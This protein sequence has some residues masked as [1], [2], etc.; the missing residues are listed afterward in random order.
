MFE[1]GE[2]GLMKEVGLAPVFY[3]R[4]AVGGHMPC[5]MYLTCGEDAAEHKK[6]WDAFS[7]AP[8]WKQL[9]NDPQYKDNMI[10]MIRALLKRTPASQL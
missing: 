4:V 6:H 2:I 9:Q 5:L 3:G 10:G 1:A 7:A 8:V